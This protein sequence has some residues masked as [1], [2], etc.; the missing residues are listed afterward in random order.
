[1]AVPV[2]TQEKD[3]NSRSSFRRCRSGTLGMPLAL[4]TPYFINCDT[5]FTAT[6]PQRL[7]SSLATRWRRRAFCDLSRAG[8]PGVAQMGSF[9]TGPQASLSPSCSDSEV[10]MA[11]FLKRKQNEVAEQRGDQPREHQNHAIMCRCAPSPVLQLGAQN[12]G[13]I[14]G[15]VSDASGSVIAGAVVTVTSAA[16]NQTR[17]LTTNASGDYSVPWGTKRCRAIPGSFR[18]FGA[19]ISFGGSPDSSLKVTALA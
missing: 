17:R 18:G 1:M 4:I 15:A 9:G 6:P 11:G 12:F 19:A 14:T 2:P 13:E 16:T 7:R 8:K 5:P 3:E 10:S